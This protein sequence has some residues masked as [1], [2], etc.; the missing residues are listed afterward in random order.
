LVGTARTQFLRAVCFYRGL[1][2]IRFKGP[3]HVY[4]VAF[5]YG[6]RG[7]CRNDGYRMTTAAEA[8]AGAATPDDYRKLI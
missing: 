7:Y 3:P 1:E 8:I 2:R 5:V 4:G 6:G